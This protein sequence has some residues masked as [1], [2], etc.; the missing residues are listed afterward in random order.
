[1]K[2]EEVTRTY[3]TPSIEEAAALHAVG[4]PILAGKTIRAADL[5]GYLKAGYYVRDGSVGFVCSMEREDFEELLQAYRDK[6]I[7]VPVAAYQDG[8]NICKR[9]LKETERNGHRGT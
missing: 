9:L 4:C 5:S 2:T 3:V 8:V 7:K 1:M 6:L